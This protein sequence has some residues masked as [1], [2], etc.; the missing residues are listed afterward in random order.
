MPALDKKFER[1]KEIL[2]EMGAVI[3][4]YSGGVDSTFLLKAALDTLGSKKV[5]AVTA[6]SE[7]YPQRELEEAGKMAEVLRVRHTVIDSEELDIPGFKDNPPDRC[8]HC[9]KEL[10]G[11]LRR[12]AEKEGIKYIL[13]GSN[14]D[15]QEDYRPGMKAAGE[16]GIRSPLME[17]A[18]TKSDIRALSKKLELNTWNKGALACLSSR[19]P[20]GQ[21]ITREKLRMVDRAENCL[22]DFGFR[23]VRA[24]HYEETV[25]IEL[26]QKDMEKLFK[27][28]GLA[29]KIVR[30]LKEIGYLYITLDLEGYQ[31]GSM[32]RVLDLEKQDS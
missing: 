5:I 29:K 28:K 4:A 13:D 27:N 8:Y 2:K 10:F 25:R 12:I 1:L 7:T 21:N 11:K 3:I 14:H 9:K 26:G 16:L 6:R 31:M 30:E 19:F 17:A 32:N 18:L 15:D 24:R 22:R 23:E 20:Y